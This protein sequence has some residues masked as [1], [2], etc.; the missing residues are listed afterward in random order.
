MQPVPWRVRRPGWRRCRYRHRSSRLSSATSRL[1]TAASA[2]A[3]WAALLAATLAGLGARSQQGFAAGAVGIHEVGP[4]FADFGI[5][6]ARGATQQ[7]E[8]VTGTQAQVFQQ[9]VGCLAD[10]AVEAWLH[11]PDIAHVRGN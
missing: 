5:D 7:Q 4:P 1:G 6:L 9:L 2:A 8:V 11:G 10:T 3:A